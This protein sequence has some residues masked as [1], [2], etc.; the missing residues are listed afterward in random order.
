[1]TNLTLMP[2]NKLFSN[3]SHV[4]IDVLASMIWPTGWY[5]LGSRINPVWYEKCLCFIQLFNDQI[6]RC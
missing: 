2:E 6:L 3:L 1:M 5:I 4:K